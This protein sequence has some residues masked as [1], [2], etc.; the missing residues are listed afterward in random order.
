MQNLTV[1][2][3]KDNKYRVSTQQKFQGPVQERIQLLRLTLLAKDLL[4]KI[5]T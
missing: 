2:V 4:K 5:W 1:L 3:Q